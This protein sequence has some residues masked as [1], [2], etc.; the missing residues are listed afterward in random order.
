M[1]ILQ[2]TK[3]TKKEKYI[4]DACSLLSIIRE[5]Q[6]YETVVSLIK[7]ANHFD[8]ELY[9]NKINLLEVYYDVSRC[10]GLSTAESFYIGIQDTSIKII[11]VLSDDVFRK[12][13]FFKT[14]YKMSLADAILLSQAYDLCASIVT[15]D[16]NDLDIVEKQ[17]NMKFVWIRQEE[18][19]QEIKLKNIKK[20]VNMIMFSDVLPDIEMAGK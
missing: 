7:Q 3:K 6:G 10:E 13:S 5:E 12:A 2:K 15:S 8:I 18:Y 11:D 20:T 14:R 1:N 17:E 19:L 16:H 4:L 9:I